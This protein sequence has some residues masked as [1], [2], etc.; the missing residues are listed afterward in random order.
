M[1]KLIKNYI[2]K[3]HKNPNQL[4]RLVD[5]LNND[6]SNFYIHV[7]LKSDI[8][9]F[10]SI[11]NYTN[12]IFIEERVNDVWGDYTQVIPFLNLIKTVLSNHSN[13]GY[14]IYLSAQDYPIKSI[15]HINSF[16]TKNQEYDFI[17]FDNFNK[18]LSPEDG[19]F[20]DQ[21]IKDY[22]I[23]FSDKRAD[24]TFMP[25]L[26]KSNF[27]DIK[28]Y[29]KLVLNGKIK[30]TDPFLKYRKPRNS[31]LLKEHYRGS[32]WWCLTYKTTEKIYEYYLTN[33]T[34]I[35]RYYEYTFCGDEQ[36]FQ[37]ILKILI[38]DDQGIKIKDYV[39]YIDFERKNVTLPV[40]FTKSDI[41]ILLSQPENKL[42]ARK[43][44][45]DIDTDIFD[46]IDKNIG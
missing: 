18:S 46:L 4:K 20:Y 38:P 10:E 12:V 31:D 37:T 3:A 43:F 1:E 33:K 7:D 25:P 41:D 24:F 42:F 35:D 11:L 15:N 36:I 21:R 5:K 14:V 2:I 29:I 8:E 32:N 44:D 34:E 17:H 40:V 23:N 39:H 16:L 26:A 45:D 9:P 28:S 13:S 22:K 19:H 6:L 30:P 27:R